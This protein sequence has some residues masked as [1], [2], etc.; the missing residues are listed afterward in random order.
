MFSNFHLSC[1]ILLRYAGYI[2]HLQDVGIADGS[3]DLVMSNCVINLS[4]DK[5][6]VV[7]GL[8]S[9]VI[10]FCIVVVFILAYIF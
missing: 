7:K 6:A 8:F 10:L 1:C 3:V 5:E 9:I 2:E 4:P